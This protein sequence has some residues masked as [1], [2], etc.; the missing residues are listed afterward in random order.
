MGQWSVN[1]D[2]RRLMFVRIRRVFWRFTE[3]NLFAISVVIKNRVR[4]V[5]LGLATLFFGS[6]RLPRG[7]AHGPA[8]KGGGVVRRLLCGAGLCNSRFR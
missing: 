1:M 7:A 4:G 3:V 6:E 2:R 8:L 5:P